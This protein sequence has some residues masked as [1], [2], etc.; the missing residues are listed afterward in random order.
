M[1]ASWRA[2]SIGCQALTIIACCALLQVAFGGC[3]QDTTKHPETRAR[4]G[5]VTID[6][7]GIA[8]GS[9]RFHSCRAR[10]GK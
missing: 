5:A 2:V 9:G 8:T 7:A 4:D 10:S 6:L 3:A 1:N